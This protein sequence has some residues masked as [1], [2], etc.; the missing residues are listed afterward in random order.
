MKTIIVYFHGYG[1]SAQSDKVARL[2]KE[3]EFDVYAFDANIDPEIAVKHVGDCIDDILLTEMHVPIKL[4]FVGTSLGGWLASKMAQMYQCEAIIINPSVTPSTSLVK[5]GVPEVICKKYADLTSSKRHKY[6][7]A[8]HDDVIDN[9][10]FIKNLTDQNYDVTI[11]SD[12][13]HRFSGKAFEE[14]IDLIHKL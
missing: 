5:Y 2:R 14:V 4:L 6:F 7:F 13:D 12:A 1:S 10:S 8:L 11:I 9:I 3:S